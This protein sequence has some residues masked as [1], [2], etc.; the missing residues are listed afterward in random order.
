MPAEHFPEEFENFVREIG[1]HCQPTT[2]RPGWKTG[3]SAVTVPIDKVNTKLRIREA[4][5]PECAAEPTRK[6]F[7][8]AFSRK[9]VKFLC[10]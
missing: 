6:I 7:T 5:E 8:R 9:N 10:R 4:I 1:R 3:T 2:G